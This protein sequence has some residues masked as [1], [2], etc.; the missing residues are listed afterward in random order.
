MNENKNE[1][2]E[3]KEVKKVKTP[4]DS[5]M[6]LLLILCAFW[7]LSMNL[8]LF[9][10]TGGNETSLDVTNGVICEVEVDDVFT[11]V[12]Y[13]PVFEADG[14]KKYEVRFRTSDSYYF[15]A[16][17]DGSEVDE[18]G[19]I[20]ENAKYKGVITYAY[21]DKAFEERTKE[22]SEEEKS[23][24]IVNLLNSKSEYAKYGDVIDIDFMYGDYIE[25]VLEVPVRD[26]LEGL[27]SETSEEMEK[28]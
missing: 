20:E 23:D 8:Q 28:E 19:N 6:I 2:Q 13:T 5:S 1:N 10:S 9:V 12:K 4:I 24:C 26:K 16:L 18:K 22:M 27:M 7:V 21:I 17:V 15:T 3:E 25:D 14:T 11:C